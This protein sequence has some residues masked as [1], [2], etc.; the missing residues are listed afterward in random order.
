[1]KRREFLTGLLATPLIVNA[2][3]LDYVPRGRL[4]VPLKPS[5][6]TRAE[7]REALWPGVVQFFGT[8]YQYRYESEYIT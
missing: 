4:L 6:L 8:E 7:I 5:V 2:G 1:M 3:V